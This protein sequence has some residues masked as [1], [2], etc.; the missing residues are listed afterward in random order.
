MCQKDI[1]DVDSMSSLIVASPS[2]GPLALA[3]ANRIANQIAKLKKVR[4]V[5]MAAGIPVC[6]YQID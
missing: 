6:R 2:D 3:E 1:D 5:E 4:E